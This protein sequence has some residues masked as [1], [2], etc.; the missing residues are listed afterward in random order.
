MNNYEKIKNMTL[1]EMAEEL[2]IHLG[3]CSAC[4]C[5]FIC[6]NHDIGKHHCIGMY[7][8]WLQAESEDTEWKN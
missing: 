7:K 1:D 3:G 8:Q 5:Y 4:A 2:Y 6:K